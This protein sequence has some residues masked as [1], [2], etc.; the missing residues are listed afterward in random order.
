MFHLWTPGLRLDVTASAS[1]P[2]A[3]GRYLF[4]TPSR[5]LGSSIFL[6]SSSYTFHLT[7]YVPGST[8]VNI[9]LVAH[10]AASSARLPSRLSS[11][12][13]LDTR[14]LSIFVNCI[15]VELVYSSLVVP[16]SFGTLNPH[17]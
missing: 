4:I 13:W 16:S 3:L 12:S 8:V 14:A 11:V 15:T 17:R 6:R 10:E 2:W 1:G 7:C 5:H 9:R